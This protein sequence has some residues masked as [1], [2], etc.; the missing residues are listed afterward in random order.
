MHRL[1]TNKA[2]LGERF[3][4]RARHDEEM[5]VLTVL[6]IM[7]F[8]TPLGT[9]VA[10][11]LYLWPNKR[12]KKGD[13]YMR[14]EKIESQ[15]EREKRGNNKEERKGQRGGRSYATSNDRCGERER[16]RENKE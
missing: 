2:F 3:F 15:I 7:F 4:L 14:E 1:D 9:V 5:T 8:K 16:E 11:F 10:C 13:V 6:L 12:T